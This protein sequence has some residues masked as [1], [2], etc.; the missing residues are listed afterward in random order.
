[1][2]GFV[3]EGAEKA[4]PFQAQAIDQLNK[5]FGLLKPIVNG[6]KKPQTPALGGAGDIGAGL[7]GLL[8]GN[9]DDNKIANAATAVAMKRLLLPRAHAAGAVTLDKI[10]NGLLKS[11]NLTTILP[12]ARMS[13]GLLKRQG[14]KD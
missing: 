3:K 2:R 5:R 8:Y 6:L 7:L 10:A 9:Q 4:D 1:M 13:G 12:V 14:R 11:N